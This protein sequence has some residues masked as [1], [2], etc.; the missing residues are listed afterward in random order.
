MSN[1]EDRI[2]H[3]PTAEEQAAFAI[4]GNRQTGTTL[5]EAFLLHLCE[6]SFLSLWSYAGVYR[7]ELDGTSKELCDVLVVFGEHL[8]IFSDKH[9]AFGEALEIKTSWTRWFKRAIEKSVNQLHG[10]DKVLRDECD[11]FIDNKCTIP[12]PF[13]LP[14][15]STRK[16]HLIAVGRGVAEAS[17][18]HFD[19]GTGSLMINTALR[20]TAHYD[21]PFTL[22]IVDQNKRFVHILDE[23]GLEAAFSS[24]TTTADFIQYLEDREKLMT[25][26]IVISSG[27]EDTVAAYFLSSSEIWRGS[28]RPYLDLP[29][30][31][32]I[33][34]GQGSWEEFKIQRD[35]FAKAEFSSRIWD[36]IIEVIS[37]S[38]QRGEVAAA[39]PATMAGQEKVLRVLASEPREMRVFLSAQIQGLHKGTPQSQVAFRLIPP[40]EKAGYAYALLCH[41]RQPE[42]YSNYESYREARRA[43]VLAY[44]FAIPSK[45]PSCQRV[46][47]ITFENE[48][49]DGYSVDV[50]IVDSEETGHAK[51]EEIELVKQL[52][53]EFGVLTDLHSWSVDD[54]SVQELLEGDHSKFGP[55]NLKP[56]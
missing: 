4:Y 9:C 46:I 13:D 7:R 3:V 5:S 21:S 1:S 29:Q 33:S 54:G 56:E 24:L 51:E 8:L 26:R 31:L 2:G 48:L 34:F 43:H 38:I 52:Q 11:L 23:I 49:S 18:E 53:E 35:Q 20:G 47:G 12:F 17:R 39:Y 50:L 16:T 6:R 27:E 15:K 42:M 10:A 41:P 55:K 45:Y 36:G 40:R 30:D 37:Q 22:G 25:E 14:H 19:G 44:C 32:A 28:F